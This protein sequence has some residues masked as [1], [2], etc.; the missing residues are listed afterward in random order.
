MAKINALILPDTDADEFIQAIVEGVVKR[1]SP[2]AEIIDQKELCKRLSISVP[3]AIRYGQDGTFPTLR[4]GGAVRYNWP[5][6]IKALESQQP[7]TEQ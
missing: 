7:K 5:S 3:T 4:M 6:V 2:P 1:L